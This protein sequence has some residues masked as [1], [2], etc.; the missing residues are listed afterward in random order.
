MKNKGF[1]ILDPIKDKSVFHMLKDLVDSQVATMEYDNDNKDLWIKVSS[2]I[3][4]RA[5]P[6]IELDPPLLFPPSTSRWHNMGFITRPKNVEVI[7]RPKGNKR[8]IIFNRKIF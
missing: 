3:G 6:L 7:I 5:R 8:T 1:I 4:R 2:K